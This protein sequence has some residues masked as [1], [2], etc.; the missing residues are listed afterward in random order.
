MKLTHHIGPAVTWQQASVE[1]NQQQ[2]VGKQPVGRPTNTHHTQP[3]IP[4]DSDLNATLTDQ[5]S[6]PPLNSSMEQCPGSN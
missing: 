5:D 4:V 1:E 2:P 6:A 3:I